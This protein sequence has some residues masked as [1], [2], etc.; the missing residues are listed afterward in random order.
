MKGH[1]MFTS[2]S[3]SSSSPSPSGPTLP[4]TIRVSKA[5]DDS[6]RRG[7]ITFLGDLSAREMFASEKEG[8]LDAE[9]DRI[10]AENPDLFGGALRNKALKLLWDKADHAHWESKI[11][12]LAG[13]VE[14]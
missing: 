13:N 3:L 8:D 11:A 5:A 7:I 12:E 1:A 9:M 2:A 14:A 6:L 10:H 4:P